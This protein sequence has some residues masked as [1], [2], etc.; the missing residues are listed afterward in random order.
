MSN[1][2]DDMM[3]RIAQDQAHHAGLQAEYWKKEAE[4]LQKEVN[5]LDKTVHYADEQIEKWKYTN[6]TLPNM[7]ILAAIKYGF[8]HLPTQLW[9]QEVRGY[10]K[11]NWNTFSDELKNDIRKEVENK[12]FSVSQ[13]PEWNDIINS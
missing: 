3:R 5:M 2:D 1:Q 9:E 8:E 11:H 7:V 6:P 12:P 4:R 13:N 10:V